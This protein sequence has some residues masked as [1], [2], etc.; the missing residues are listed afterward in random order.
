MHSDIRNAS[1]TR[2]KRRGE[3]ELKKV[4]EKEGPGRWRVNETKCGIK[5]EGRERNAWRYMEGKSKTG[6]RIEKSTQ[7]ERMK[8]EGQGKR[9][10]GK[11]LLNIKK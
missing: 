10:G 5:G 2:R 4:K 9:L 1:Q 11:I 3:S 8:R 7:G 6:R